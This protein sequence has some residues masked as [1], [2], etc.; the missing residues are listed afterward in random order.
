MSA[1]HATQAAPTR[2]CDVLTDRHSCNDIA[3]CVPH[4]GGPEEEQPAAAVLALNQS[5]LRCNNF[6]RCKA[7][8]QWAL[9]KGFRS[10]VSMPPAR[11]CWDR[12][13]RK[14]V[15][16]A[17]LRERL[18]PCDPHACGARGN[19]KASYIDS[20]SPTDC[21]PN[22]GDGLLQF[23]CIRWPTLQRLLLRPTDNH[24]NTAQHCLSLLL[25]A[26]PTRRHT[27]GL[28]ASAAATTHVGRATMSSR[29][30]H[31]GLHMDATSGNHAASDD[32]GSRDE[33]RERH[34]AMACNKRSRWLAK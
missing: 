22:I 17:S 18:H 25:T 28:N 30:L 11:A 21:A 24:P 6:A 34:A 27:N 3:C 31:D 4:G 10:A 29:V 12:P 1:P 20:Y 7:A 32:E 16:K 14:M 13:A 23:S 9:V 2:T 8:K 26:T 19:C 33:R 15:N 5:L